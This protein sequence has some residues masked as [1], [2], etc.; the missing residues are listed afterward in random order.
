MS[1][2]VVVYEYDDTP[3]AA[4]GDGAPVLR[5]HAAPAAPGQSGVRGP[6]TLCGKDTFAMGTASWQPAGHPGSGW[7]PREYA[8]RVCPACDDAA[9]G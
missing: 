8:D 5:V 4:P 7:Y 3:G 9:D 2:T 1:G 6:R